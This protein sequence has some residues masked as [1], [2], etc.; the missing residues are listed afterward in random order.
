[1]GEWTNQDALAFGRQLEWRAGRATP[2]AVCRIEL[3]SAKGF[4]DTDCGSQ[5]PGLHGV[6]RVVRPG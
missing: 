2:S 6:D 1:M 3:C 5:A 4:A